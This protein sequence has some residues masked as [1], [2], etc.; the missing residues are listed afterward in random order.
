MTLGGT[1]FKLRSS[2]HLDPFASLEF[3]AATTYTA[4]EMTKLNNT[5]GVI[6]NAVASGYQAV[7]VYLASKIVVPCV[8]I[9]SGNLA[10][11]AEGCKIYFDAANKEVTN[12]SA[13]NTL[14]GIVNVQP[15]VGDEE[16]E[17]YLD[18]LL[19]IVS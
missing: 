17:I 19:G 16:V 4:G 9:S 3:T 6:M 18:G 12:V 15:S 14:C 10:S 11:F 2:T 7:L 13:G 1:D 8:A 5:V